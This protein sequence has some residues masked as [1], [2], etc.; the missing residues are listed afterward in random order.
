MKTVKKLL[1]NFSF[2]TLEGIFIGCLIG[3]FQFLVVLLA[4]YAKSLFFNHSILYI[5]MTVLLFLFLSIVTFFLI[6][7]IKDID[8]SGVPSLLNHLNNN[9]K[10]EYKYSLI[11]MYISSLISLFSHYTLGSEGPSVVLA[12][13]SCS[14]FNDLFKRKE[15]N[16]DVLLSAAIGFGCAFLSPISGVIYYLESNKKAIKDYKEIIKALYLGIIAF[17]FTYLISKHHLLILDNLP[18]LNLDM[19]YILLTIFLFNLLISYLFF[20]SITFIKYIF[21]KYRDKFFIK[22]RS[23]IFLILCLILNYT[24]FNIMGNGL[25][26]L[27]IDYIHYPI[28]ILFLFLLLRSFLICL[29]GTGKLTGGLVLPTMSIGII[30]AQIVIN[31]LFNNNLISSEYFSLIILIS[32]TMVFSFV[33]KNPFTG[34]FLVFSTILT[35]K[36]SFVNGLIIFTILSFTYYIGAFLLDKINGNKLYN[37]FIKISLLS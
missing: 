2:Y 14:L 37:E 27:N 16:K 7:N 21:Q 8:G 5:S 25:D 15:A 23:F 17:I 11:G 29:F 10:I 36:F 33:N 34:A 4:S 3:S 1:F 20:K 6:K 13:K 19:L 9:K 30:T 18:T 28:Y 35:N 32:M 31:Y 22:Y 12:G 26:L 24:F